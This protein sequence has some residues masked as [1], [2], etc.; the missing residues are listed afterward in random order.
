[1][2]SVVSIVVLFVGIMLT[3]YVYGQFKDEPEE[4]ANNAPTLTTQDLE[5]DVVRPTQPACYKFFVLSMI[6][7]AIQTF[8]GIACAI[9]FVRPLGITVCNIL[10]FSVFRSYHTVFQ[11]YWFFVAWVGTIFF[12]PR[13]SKEPAGQRLLIELLFV[14]CAVVAAGG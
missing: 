7:F 14:G 10:P 6:A 1:M 11:I 4:D 12:L 3:L 8:A 5:M 2:W 13:F 9:D